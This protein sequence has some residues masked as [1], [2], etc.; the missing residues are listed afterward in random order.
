MRE[1]KSANGFEPPLVTA[2]I[3][4]ALGRE[5]KTSEAQ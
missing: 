2:E 5:R 4:Y 1:F 3:G